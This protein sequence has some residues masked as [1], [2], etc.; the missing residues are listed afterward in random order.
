VDEQRL[1]RLQPGAAVQPEMGG[2]V[3][4]VRRRGRHVTDRVGHR[5]GAVR[6]EDRDFGERTVGQRGDPDDAGADPVV[7]AVGPD[8]DDHP[9]G[10]EP[11]RERQWR[12]QLVAAPPEEHVLE[13][14]RG[15]ADPH[16]DL[17][18]PWRRGRHVVEGERGRRLA[19]LVNP[20]GA[21]YPTGR[22]PNA[23]SA[24]SAAI[25]ASS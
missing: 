15:R 17:A 4:D 5:V 13:P 14:E 19:V 8:G 18:R 10:L 22:S 7:V 21:H 6:R 16:R 11:G 3:R 1:A 12:P 25:R 9:G 23:P 2:R 24:A 20:Q